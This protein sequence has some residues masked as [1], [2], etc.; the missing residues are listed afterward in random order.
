MSSQ[1]ILVVITGAAGSGKSTLAISNV[2][3]FEAE[4][5]DIADFCRAYL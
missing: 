1:P 4:I 2:R 5:A 3:C